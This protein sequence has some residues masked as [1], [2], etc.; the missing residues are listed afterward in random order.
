[1]HC[2]QLQKDITSAAN[3]RKQHYG[4]TLLLNRQ[5]GGFLHIVDGQQT[6]TAL[7]LMGK[8]YI[9]R[10]IN[11]QE[12][13]TPIDTKAKVNEV[14]YLG[15]PLQ[16]IVCL[17]LQNSINEPVQSAYRDLVIDGSHTQDAQNTNQPKTA[18]RALCVPEQRQKNAYR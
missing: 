2:H 9:R 5:N 3:L 10:L 7:T 18:D 8:A 15:N 4:G 12:P 14:L 6:M 13:P 1:V 16:Q 11:N 17:S